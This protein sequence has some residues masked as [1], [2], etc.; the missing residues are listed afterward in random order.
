MEIIEALRYKLMML[1]IPIKGLANV[2][3]DNEAV[4]KNTIIPESTLKKTIP[5]PIIG[6]R[7]Q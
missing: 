3:Y 7:K 4:M 1:G 6:V 5:L 2:Y